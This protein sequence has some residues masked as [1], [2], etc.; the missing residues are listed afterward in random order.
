MAESHRGRGRTTGI[1]SELTPKRAPFC[2]RECLDRATWGAASRR[3]RLLWERIFA[4]SAAPVCGA[5]RL[6]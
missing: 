3:P 4:R 5:A 1:P 2:G 6:Q